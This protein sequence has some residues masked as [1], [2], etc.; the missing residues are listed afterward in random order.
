MAHGILDV[1][2]RNIGQRE[3]KYDKRYF[4]RWEVNK[5][6]ECYGKDR[7]PLVQSFTKDLSLDGAS[8]IVLGHPRVQHQVQLKIY[9]SN[10]ENFKTRGR[11]AWAKSEPTHEVLGIVFEHL[12]KKAFEL[13]MRHAFELSADVLSADGSIKKT[14]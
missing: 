6:V 10:K 4:P 14:I 8:I 11:V 3:K 9:L 5:R 7:G 2:Q 12:S 1:K 13:M